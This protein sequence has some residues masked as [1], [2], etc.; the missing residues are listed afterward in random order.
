MCLPTTRRAFFGNVSRLILLSCA[1][2]KILRLWF[3]VLLAVLLPVRGAVAATMLCPM[4]GGK[5]MAMQS[6]HAD[7]D[8]HAMEASAGHDDHAAMSHA[9]I[10]HDHPSGSDQSDGK[11]NLCVA[12]CSITPLLSS[13]PTLPAPQEM[14]SA[15]FPPLTAAPPSF[16][17]DGQERPPRST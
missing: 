14:G 2:V 9:S 12:F 7:M 4:V 16:L 15:P 3:I 17:S 13:L 11:C 10:E 6:H 8:H 5:P 1:I